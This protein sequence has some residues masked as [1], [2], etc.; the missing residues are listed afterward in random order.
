MTTRNLIRAMI[1]AGLTA[2][3]AWPAYAG[4]CS[5]TTPEFCPTTSVPEPSSI[6][7][8]AAGAGSLAWYLR[9]RR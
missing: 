8:L 4:Q 5:P 3:Y 2:I 9:K 7:L 6:L 1:L